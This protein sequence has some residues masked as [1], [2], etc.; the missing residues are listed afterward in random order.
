MWVTSMRSKDDVPHIFRLIPNLR[1]AVA[2]IEDE[3]VQ[4]A[5]AET[6]EL[7]EA[8]A[9]DIVDSDY[10]IRTKDENADIYIA[11]YTD[12][13]DLNEQQGDLCSFINYRE[14]LPEGECNARRGAELIGYHHAINE[15]CG[16]GEPNSYDI[17][18]YNLNRYNKRICRYFHLSHLANALVNGD[19]EAAL[20]LLDGL[21]ERMEQEKNTPAED[22]QY[23]YHDWWRN[24]ALYF[25]QSHSYGYPLT[26]EETRV[27]HEYYLKAIDEM[28][29]WPYWDLWDDSVVD[30]TT[31]S[32][33]PPNCV[34]TDGE[35]DCWWRVE[36]L[37]Q[38]FE[39]CWS[40]LVNPAS[41]NF[42]DCSIVRDPSEMGRSRRRL[43]AVQQKNTS[44]G[45]SHWVC[46]R[47]FICAMHCDWLLGL[48]VSLR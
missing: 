40:P 23:P 10:R 38:L 29:D 8:F 5:C 46:S 2:E 13:Q 21:E 25:T 7:L 35:T 37:G 18:A 12:D 1:Y 47:F 45:A 9:K 15:D 32:Y 28:K 44:T 39:N 16:R 19:N 43:T 33:R 41:A 22:M 48:V 36:D 6:L 42:V 34:T 30:G 17:I 24:L 31:G 11:G 14:W 27:I 26:S 4:S 3:N 20:Q